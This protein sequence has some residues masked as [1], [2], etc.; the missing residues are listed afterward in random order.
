MAMKWIRILASAVAMTTFAGITEAAI[1]DCPA[2]HGVVEVVL[3]SGLP[4]IL[5]DR[6]GDVALPGEPFDSTDVYA[7]GHKHRRYIFVWN[8]GSR[9]IVATEQGGIAL[10][11]AIFVYD[12]SKDG[13]T[14]TLIDERMGLVNNVC[15]AASK[16]AA[17]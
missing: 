8:I 11:S 10:R 15:T 3:P 1:S 2:P 9:W 16:L 13:K 14:A 17:P 5:R 7:K 6:I 4:G 12:L